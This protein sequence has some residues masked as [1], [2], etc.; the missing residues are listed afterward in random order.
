MFAY[1]KLY[2]GFA[3]WL[4][5]A[6]V[7]ATCQAG[8]NAAQETVLWRIGLKDNSSAEFT[9][10]SFPASYQVP[11][12]WA[13]RTAWPEIPPKSE[14]NPRSPSGKL[15]TEIHYDLAQ[16][17]QHGLV[18]R[19]KTVNSSSFVTELAVFANGLPCGILQTVG[20]EG[21]GSSGLKFG[22]TYQ[23]YIPREF[24]QT[25]DNRLRVRKLGHP[26]NR[27]NFEYL[28]ITLDW[29]ELA[30]PA[31]AVT[32]PLHSR[33]VRIGSAWGRFQIDDQTV[34]CE[35]KTWEWFGT[36]W[37]GNPMR[38]SFWANT[39][40]EIKRP[41]EYLEA[42]RNYNMA[43][44]VDYSH[45]MPSR[46]TG[47]PEWTDAQGELH[48]VWRKKLDELLA[49]YGDLIQYYE[50]SNEPCMN[51]TDAS[52]AANLAV[53]R[54]LHSH[55]PKHLKVSA[56]A[57]TYGG[58]VGEPKDWDRSAENRRKVEAFCD[59]TNG[60]AY[61]NSYARDQGN[62]IET[63]RTFSERGVIQNGFPKEFINTEMGT[64]LQYHRDFDNL[65]VNAQ[66]NAS[67]LDRIH[68][69]HVGFC[70]LFLHFTTFGP[71]DVRLLGGKPYEPE[72]WVSQ[73][74]PK[75]GPNHDQQQDSPLSVL[76]RMTLAYGTHGRP[77]AYEYVNRGEVENRLVYFR[78]VDTSALAPLAG[79][80]ATSQ[81]ILLSFVN[82]SRQE[83]TL[84]VRVAFPLAGVYRGLRFGPE[85]QYLAAKSDLELDASPAAT[86]VESLGP[87][88]SVEYIL[89]RDP[90]QT[91]A[92]APPA[93]PTNLQ[94]EG[95][96]IGKIGYA[97]LRWKIGDPEA[98]CKVQRSEDGKRF[99]QVDEVAAGVS[100]YDDASAEGPVPGKTYF[101]RIKAA[102]RGGDSSPGAAVKVTIPSRPAK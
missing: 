43:S 57:F 26:F 82:F 80:G 59:T 64:V 12:D 73:S 42:A 83:Q 11:A 92:I 17:P 84:R 52:L 6:I 62:L 47:M 97:R 55:K 45:C 8:E 44:V 66:S 40:G 102:N 9:G 50:V 27:D 95:G 81:K 90:A 99:L 31:V 1:R 65:G 5:V 28:S 86:V 87:G 41:R 19:L 37:C 2:Y 49:K 32:E 54:Y 16:V 72:T 71:D 70:D 38:V 3:A 18:F 53:A 48:P 67:I 74:F 24:L 23:V 89:Q 68:R 76:R 79:S 21:W 78:A 75:T 51:I 30:A 98:V 4:L 58:G 20:T 100:A 39:W 63:I 13:T 60:H 36:A 46:R 93:A 14:A 61:G 22:N 77:L 101:Y 35:P 7:V 29:L 85:E 33:Y 56:P 25:S 15:D 69:A 91:R 34:A 96:R 88:E 94:V 10:T